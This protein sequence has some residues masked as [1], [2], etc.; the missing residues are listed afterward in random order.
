MNTSNFYMFNS[1]ISY[2]P[3]YFY[4]N[5]SFN[6]SVYPSLHSDFTFNTTSKKIKTKLDKKMLDVA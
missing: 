4:S 6:S 5:P 2:F 1:S 3:E